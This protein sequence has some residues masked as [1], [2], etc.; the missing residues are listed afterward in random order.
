MRLKI[1]CD[2]ECEKFCKILWEVNNAEDEGNGAPIDRR[3]HTAA[4]G[5]HLSNWLSGTMRSKVGY[6][7]FNKS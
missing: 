5:P 3:A 7:V 4:G 1:R 2:G 6:I